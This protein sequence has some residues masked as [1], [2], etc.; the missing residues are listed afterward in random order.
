M[1]FYKK[2]EKYLPS[3]CSTS[4]FLVYPLC[5]RPQ[6]SADFS[7]RHSAP[8]KLPPSFSL[9]YFLAAGAYPLS[10]S[11]PRSNFSGR[12]SARFM[13]HGPCLPAPSQRVGNLPSAL[14]C[15]ALASLSLHLSL[16]PLLFPSHAIL[17]WRAHHSHSSSS[18]SSGTVKLPSA[19]LLFP[20][21]SSE[22]LHGHCRSSLLRPWPRPPFLRSLFLPQARS[23]QLRFLPY[24]RV[25]F[26]L[27]AQ[28]RTPLL[29]WWVPRCHDCPVFGPRRSALIHVAIV[30][31]SLV[32]ASRAIE[33]IVFL[34]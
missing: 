7:G 16:A 5:C 15:R 28:P 33:L 17:L 4:L 34:V 13:L 8:G 2:W 30:V 32:I 18:S 12:S 20:D 27:C 1:N 3:H 24:A 29:P 10:C 11:A 25:P 31:S 23:S 6:P 14:Q 22:P 26:S 21:H 9:G 19:T